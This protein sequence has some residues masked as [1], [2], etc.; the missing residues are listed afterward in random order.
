MFSLG[1]FDNLPVVMNL[2]GKTGMETDRENVVFH[3]ISS[4]GRGRVAP[5]SLWCV[6]LRVAMAISLHARAE[7][8][9]RFARETVRRVG[10]ASCSWLMLSEW[11]AVSLAV[12]PAFRDYRVEGVI[13]KFHR[14]N[15]AALGSCKI[16]HNISAWL[17]CQSQRGF[18]LLACFNEIPRC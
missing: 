17:I 13:H 6:F 14:I 3:F 16:R 2:S 9:R 12:I 11:Q 15:A 4:G 7:M 5:R 1:V 10:T 8:R 18:K